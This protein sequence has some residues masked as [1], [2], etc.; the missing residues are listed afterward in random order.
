MAAIDEVI[1]RARQGGAGFSE[2]KQFKLARRRAIEKLRRFALADPYFYILE[3]IQAAIA[4]GADFVDIA[5]A[6]GEV[7]ISWTGGVLREDELAQLFDFLFAS[8]ERLDLAHVRSLALGV[9][10]LLL[11]EP[12]QVVIESGDGTPD[13]TA[14]MVVRSGAESVEV[15]R[16]Q[17]ELRGT[18]VRASKLDREKVGVETG[19]KGGDDGGLEF[20]TIELRCLAAPVPLVFNGQSMFGWSRQRVPKL[21]GYQKVRTFDEGDLYGSIG[22]RGPGGQASFQLLTHGVWVQSYQ[23]ILIPGHQF[24]GVICFDRLHKTVDHSGFV[25]DDRFTEMWLRLRPHAEALLGGKEVEGNKITSA[26][27]LAYSPNQLRELLREQPRVVVLA[28]YEG[29]SDATSLPIWRA[30]TIARALDAEL[31]RVPDT[32]VSAVRVL[33]TR[34]LLLW[35]PH[36]GDGEDQEFYSQ[37]PLEL[38]TSHLLPSVQLPAPSLDKLV[39]GLVGELAQAPANSVW[40]ESWT[41]VLD[42]MRDSGRLAVEA[43]EGTLVERVT[44]QLRVALGETGAISA[45]LWTPID[46]GEAAGGLLVRVTTT[47][48]LLDQR[49]FVSAYPGRILD[50]ELP[51]AQPST[52]RRHSMAL[53]IAEAFA[54]LAVPVL[55]EQDRRAL[56][57]LGVGKMTPDSPAARLAL[58]VL[59]RVTVTRLRGARPGRMSPGLSF[60]LLRPIAGADPF[61]LELLRTVSGRPLS[62]RAL[63]LLCDETA[64]LVYGTIAEVPA[65][66]D[67]LDT[68]RILALDAASERTLIG[69]LGEASYVRVDV[70]DVLTEHDGVTVRDIALGLRKYPDFPLPIEG[71]VGRVAELDEDGRA[72]LLATLVRGLV[73]RMFGRADEPDGDPLALEEHRRQAVRHLQWYAC[74]SLAAGHRDALESSGLLDI[75]LFLDIDQ[76]PWS[77]RQVHAA[78][79]SREGLLVH[80][81]HLLGAAELGLLTEAAR[82]HP[83][84]EGQPNSLAVSAFTHRLLLPLGRVRIAFDFD[85]DDTEAARTSGTSASAFIVQAPFE[86]P[87]ATG[88]LGIPTQRPSECRIQVRVRG[89][90]SIAALDAQHLGMVGSLELD[91]IEWD[92]AAA[93]DLLR[94]IDAHGQSLL[95]ALIQELPKLA[96]DPKRLDAATHVLLTHL[97]EQLTL[98]VGPIGVVAELGSALAQRIASLPLFDIGAA[99]LVSAQRMIERF[100]RHFDRS[101]KPIDWGAVLVADALPSVRAWLDA[102][103]QPA[104]VVTPASVGARARVEPAHEPTSAWPTWDPARRLPLDVLATNIGYWLER[105]RPD[106]RVHEGR[107]ERATRVWIASHPVSTEPNDEWIAG[108][109]LRTD[110]YGAHPLV[111]QVC[112]SPIASNL[113]WMLLAVYAHIN[114]GTGPM[115]RNEHELQFQLIVADA[116]LDGRLRVLAP[117]G[118]L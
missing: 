65:D 91:N 111:E 24:G 45:T 103:L 52:M 41:R 81:A 27:G 84:T 74:R 8:K 49:F 22:L 32:Q 46:P 90:G 112:A 107:R 60:S 101:M 4:G 57:G 40:A 80:H 54:E 38:P 117:K 11:F 68:D 102:R 56:A 12:E 50:V 89:R 73:D 113:A 37:P 35:R 70:R 47:G 33:G 118:S 71:A 26:G 7:L 28:P 63:A 42:D 95:G 108:G 9:N 99:T 1:A 61:S 34:E 23:Y 85:L 16:G 21:F 92:D 15:G 75:P 76:R 114:A 110:I 79:C 48:R 31:L 106:P 93:E 78:L 83:T 19:R 25:Q 13:G 109:D 98:T 97:S 64:G 58:Q 17:G 44:A 116:L 10:A 30:N 29:D 86:S 115:I 105:L 18:Y 20:A 36:V 94:Q 3:I 43:R 14:R 66:L 5:C 100:R 2:R 87:T 53:G 39:S 67:G 96:D 51:T 62:L 69:L 72:E 55:R 59:S 104:G 82:S 88:V 77:A 6:E